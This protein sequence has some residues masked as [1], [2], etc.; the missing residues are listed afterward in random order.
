MQVDTALSH[1]YEDPLHMAI[2]LPHF[3]LQLAPST[4]VGL[5]LLPV[6]HPARIK[7]VAIVVKKF[8]LIYISPLRF[9]KQI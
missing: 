3:A 2:S 1:V 7:A 6:A 8:T 4:V 9:I 5:K